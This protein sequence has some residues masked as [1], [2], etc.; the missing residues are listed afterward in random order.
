LKTTL[1]IILSISI[2]IVTENKMYLSYTGYF[3]VEDMFS[4]HVV[5]EATHR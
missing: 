3:E 1:A 4:V 5:V 2:M